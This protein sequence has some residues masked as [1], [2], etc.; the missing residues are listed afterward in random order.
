M[1]ALVKKGVPPV[2]IGLLN[3]IWCIGYFIMG[4]SKKAIMVIIC[5]ILGNLVC[6]GG[7]VVAILSILDG[8]AV[9]SAVAAGEEVDENEYKNEL[10]YKI[11]KILHK[12]A[13]FKGGE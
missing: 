3:L 2:V 12:D 7:L 1:A 11:C 13:I 5:A 8:L 6:I 10:L 9:A 4:Q